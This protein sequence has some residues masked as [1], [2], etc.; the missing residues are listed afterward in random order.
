MMSYEYI[1]QA[2]KPP[3]CSQSIT[4]EKQWTKQSNANSIKMYVLSIGKKKTREK[5]NRFVFFN[6]TLV[7]T[8]NY[9]S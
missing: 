3:G 4:H 9:N 7:F 6:M 8:Y 5:D 2:L 1:T